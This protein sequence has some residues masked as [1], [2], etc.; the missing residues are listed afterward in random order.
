[1]SSEIALI[2]LMRL[3]KAVRIEIRA[4]IAPKTSSIVNM[5][6]VGPVPGSRWRGIRAH[7]HMLGRGGVGARMPTPLL[8]LP[9]LFTPRKGAHVVMPYRSVEVRCLNVSS[10]IAW[11]TMVCQQPTSLRKQ[12]F[13]WWIFL[14]RHTLYMC[15]HSPL[16]PPHAPTHPHLR[17][18]VRSPARTLA[19]LFLYPHHI[20]N[21]AS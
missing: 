3:A 1:M 11:F 15:A 20:F 5:G 21:C 18:P 8:S 7:V 16:C 4:A 9:P 2:L 17:L 10:I 13:F 6:N 12:E 19:R 14:G